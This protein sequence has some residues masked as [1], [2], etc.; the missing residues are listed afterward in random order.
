MGDGV[1]K[2][3]RY[4]IELN[5]GVKLEFKDWIAWQSWSNA[6]FRKQFIPDLADHNFTE[7]G[8][9]KYIFAANNN[10]NK[11]TL[12]DYVINSLKKADGSPVD[13]LKSIS[14][15]QAQKLFKDNTMNR[16]NYLNKIISNIENDN[17]F[18]QL[19]EIVD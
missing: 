4:D 18:N 5:G 17:I 15:E 19:F 9:K 7:F 6:S 16:A 2:L 11:N 12:K 3:R 1:T 10:I 8:Q 14:F 13:E